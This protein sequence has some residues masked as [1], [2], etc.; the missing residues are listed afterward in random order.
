MNIGIGLAIFIVLSVFLNLLHI[1]LDW[2]I[3]LFLGATLPLFYL[4]KI[5]IN[6]K[7]PEINLKLTKS[8]IYILIVLVL[9]SFTFYMYHKGAF[10]YPYLEDDDPWDHAMSIKYIANGKSAFVP[11]DIHN[12]FHYIDA[13]PPAYDII[14]GVLH[15]TSPDLMWTMKFFNALII[16]LGIIFFYFF[17]KHFTGNS[18]KALFST[19]ALTMIP[20]YL[21]H[22]IWA[23]SLIPTLF[24][25][26][27]YCLEQI[28][29]SKKWFFISA[30]VI[31]TLPLTH[32]TQ[33][34]KLGVMFFIYWIVKATMQ[35]KWLIKTIGSISCGYVFAILLWWVPMLIKYGFSGILTEGL[36]QSAIGAATVTAGNRDILNWFIGTIGSATRFYGLSDFLLL[37]K[38]GGMQ[39]FDGHN[40]INNPVGIGIV[41][42]ALAVIA[43]VFLVVRYKTIVKE[44]N[45]YKLIALL[46]FLFTFLGLYGGTIIPI[47]LIS[48]RFWMLLAIPTSILASEAVW[49]L[50]AIGKSIKIRKWMI[51]AVLVILIWFTSGQQKFAVNTAMWGSGG[52]L[53]PAPGALYSFLWMKQ[54]LQPNT[55][56]F[57][58]PYLGAFTI[59]FN[60]YSCEWCPD[61]IDFREVLENKSPEDM[62]DWLKSR[63]YQY[64]MLDDY[65]AKNNGINE[66]IS[67][68][69]EMISSNLYTPIYQPEINGQKLPSLVFKVN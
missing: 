34:V 28:K 55:N 69:N 19:F 22:F 14:L 54:N 21:S 27:V 51:V 26:A 24:F 5:I 46:W 61:V 40:M 3:F 16:S 47:A 36:G 68:I 13:Y 8:N 66:T 57:V 9:F 12:Q 10:A 60:L 25:V 2:K 67:K 17:L 42:F 52:W 35:K 64:L 65:Y 11:E 33:P 31:A 59:G 23:H 58:F 45:G 6:K 48:F 7:I 43:V 56:V 18:S 32:P 44:T 53:G 4:I 29:H 62:H 37:N 15:Q 20:C 49:L 41:L 38:P 63:G 30:I 50:F 1:P 39:L